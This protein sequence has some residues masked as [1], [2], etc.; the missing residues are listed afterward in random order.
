MTQIGNVYA[1]GL[2]SLAKEEGLE[3]TILQELKTLQQAFQENPDFVKILAA[4]NLS[5][6]ERCGIL[7]DS[8]R[9]RVQ[10]YVLNFLKILTEKGYMRH[11]SDCCGAYTRQYN[12]D[13]GILPVTA[14]SA[15]AMTEDQQKRLCQ[16]L[17]Q[18]T[19]KTVELQCQIDPAC[20]GGVRLD[21][22]G[23]RVDG[24]VKNRLES[25]SGLLHN[26]VL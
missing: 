7:D 14:V 21:Y 26:T 10:P 22:D 9:G 17:S 20:L 11:F 18:V 15:V 3:K 8:F 4:P 2:Y 6:Q 13:N 19:G 24:T 5:K 16:K 23:R 1:Q 25:I 12:E